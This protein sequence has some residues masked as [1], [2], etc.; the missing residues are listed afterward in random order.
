[1][2]VRLTLILLV[3]VVML[4]LAMTVAVAA[5]YLAR[6]DGG[7]YRASIRSGTVGFAATVTTAT[8]VVGAFAAM[9]R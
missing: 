3:A 5:A 6:R 1:M 9:A 4:M 8:A 2:S 7:S